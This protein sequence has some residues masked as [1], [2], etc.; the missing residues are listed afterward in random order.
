MRCVRLVVMRRERAGRMDSRLRA[1]KDRRLRT[2]RRRLC[3][4][5]PVRSGTATVRGLTTLR[6]GG[7]GLHGSGLRTLSIRSAEPVVD[8]RRRVS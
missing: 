5:A 1:E 2:V 8:L 6:S 3:E 7:R 4:P